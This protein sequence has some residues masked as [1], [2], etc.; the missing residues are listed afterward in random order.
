[1]FWQR[2]LSW[3]E[4]QWH[5]PHETL[6]PWQRQVLL[7][8]CWLP[9]DI[10][11][12]T[13]VNHFRLLSFCEPPSCFGSLNWILFFHFSL[14]VFC[15]LANTKPSQV[16]SHADSISALRNRHRKHC[17][18]LTSWPTTH[19]EKLTP[20]AT[21]SCPWVQ[22][23]CKSIFSRTQQCSVHPRKFLTK[24]THAQV[25]SAYSEDVRDNYS[26]HQ[27]MHND[28]NYLPF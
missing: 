7:L 19:M 4:Q 1:M 20:F 2:D 17:Q 9:S 3:S 22:S 26:E 28:K 10:P 25:D 6:L 16:G 21:E 15:I 8:K 13:T 14:L 11:C 12:S 24:Q 5:S 23:P 18:N 27:C